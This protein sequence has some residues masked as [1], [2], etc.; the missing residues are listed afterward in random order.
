[1]R[2]NPF[3][4]YLTAEDRLQIACLNWMKFQ[5]PKVFVVHP[6]N[7][8]RRTPYERYKASVLGM[9]AGMPDIMIYDAIDIYNGLAVE[10]KIGNNKSTPAQTVVQKRLEGQGW[11][12]ERD[13]KDLETFIETVNTYFAL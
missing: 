6:F 7:E 13:V 11:R 8:G 5:H 10:L 4:K 2:R 9:V 12:V 3:F 1:M